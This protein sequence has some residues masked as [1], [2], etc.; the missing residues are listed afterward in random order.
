MTQPKSPLQVVYVAVQALLPYERNSRTHS[1][2]Q[3]D[4]IAASI[5]EF[6]FTNPIL[7]DENHTVVAGHGR[8]MAA[9]KRGMQTVPC[10]VLAGLSDAQKRAY[11]ITDNRL[12]EAGSSWDEDML[13]MELGDLSLEDGFDLTMT[14]FTEKDL[15][16]LLGETALPS[17]PDIE[18]E[19]TA[20]QHTC[21]A[22]G[23]T[24]APG[25]E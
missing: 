14:G 4:Q 15:E 20:T 18:P 1:P 2:A 6:G 9:K 3:V 13:L 22:C 10:I 17:L 8:L 12:A 16:R 7:I 11:T 19:K 24:W 21:P 25:S 23:H 5:G